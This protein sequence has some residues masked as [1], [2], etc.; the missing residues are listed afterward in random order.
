MNH[1]QKPMNREIKKILVA[2]RGEIAV[3]VLR[4]AKEMGIATVAIYSEPD[5]KALH[6]LL[7]DEVRLVGPAPSS[8]SYL[9]QKAVLDA[10]L[11]T[12]ADAIHPGYGFLAENAGFATLC[13]EAGIEFIGPAPKTI[14]MM[15]DKLQARELARRAGVPLVPGSAGPVDPGSVL[16]EAEAIGFPVMIKA[17]AGGGGKGMRIARHPGELQSLF[18]MARS[19]AQSAFGSD[20][21][22]LERFV[23]E[24]RHIEIQ[25]LADKHGNV[26]HLFERECSV[27]RRH[28]KVIEE[29]PASCLEQHTRDEMAAAAVELARQSGYI[30]AGTVEFLFDA[31]RGEFY[32]LEVNTRL[33]VEHPVTEMITG[34]DL[35]VQQILVA[36]G[37]PL[38]LRQEDLFVR[39][40][41][42]ECRIYAEDPSRGFIPSPGL[43]RKLRFPR[44]PGV[45]VDEGIYEGY[46]VPIHYD[47]LLA[48]LTCWATTRQAAI[49]RTRRALSECVVA[50][51]KT[52]IEHY[53]H[54]LGSKLFRN[55]GYT[56]KI[57][58]QIALPEPSEEDLLVAAIAAGIARLRGEEKL[59]EKI[60]ENGSGNGMSPWKQAGRRA[61]LRSRW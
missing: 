61:V 58:E 9:D 35:V 12:G 15:G 7:A 22:Y 18:Q 40:A 11:E 51:I 39:G 53:H 20:S 16:E 26:V 45:R 34:V 19:E 29:S 21:V 52:P 10:A 24:P 41:A 6:T 56:T 27:Q 2:N 60:T 46:E 59:S 47:P 48:K 43:I 1:P 36:R 13:Q 28:Q 49:A 5:R 14:A 31:R 50:G 23:E 4:A 17:S 57:L 25:I 3:R 33:Q 8:A 32:F 55:G 42:I 44:G 54:I 30:G 37:Q 38:E